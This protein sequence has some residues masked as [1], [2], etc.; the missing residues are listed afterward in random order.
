MTEPYHLTHLYL[1][2][3]ASEAIAAYWLSGNIKKYRVSAARS[4][5]IKALAA[6]DAGIWSEQTHVLLIKLI[7]TAIV[8]STDLDCTAESQAEAVLEAILDNCLPIPE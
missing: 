7:A 3:A 8:D 5:L 2:D 1:R 4:H 6:S